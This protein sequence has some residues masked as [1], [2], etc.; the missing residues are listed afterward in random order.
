M[1]VTPEQARPCSFVNNPADTKLFTNSFDPI[2]GMNL[3]L[4]LIE[5]FSRLVE[6]FFLFWL[7]LIVE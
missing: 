5:G 3:A 2:S 6:A 1:L 4:A 7:Y